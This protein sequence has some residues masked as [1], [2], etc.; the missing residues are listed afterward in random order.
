MAIG[1]GRMFGF[2]F[3]ENFNYPY[4]SQSVTEFWRRWH[5]SLSS[6]FRDYLYIPLGGNRYGT[7]RTYGNLIFVFFICGLWHGASWSFIVWGLLHGALLV[8]ERLALG[9][10]LRRTSPVVRHAYLVLAILVGWVFFRAD[11]LSHAITFLTAMFGAAPTVGAG[12]KLALYLNSEVAVMLGIGIIASLP[13][14]PA[15]RA[16]VFGKRWQGLPA[17]QTGLALARVSLYIGVFSLALL[18]LASGTHN[19]F[20]Y[21]RF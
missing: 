16:M 9:D 14:F 20:I 11:N 6:W 2:K 17:V 12:T 19:P 13:V 7:A 1:L 8:A 5:I 10:W 21:F 3:N 18:W 15:V 4:V